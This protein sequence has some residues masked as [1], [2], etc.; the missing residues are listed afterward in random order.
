MSASYL[1]PRRI[2]PGIAW[3]TVQKANF[4]L[5]NAKGCPY[6]FDSSRLL[7]LAPHDPVQGSSVNAPLPIQGYSEISKLITSLSYNGARR[8]GRWLAQNRASSRRPG[9]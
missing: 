6:L 5:D 2:C 7:K 9:S 8:E 4:H 1:I 3:R